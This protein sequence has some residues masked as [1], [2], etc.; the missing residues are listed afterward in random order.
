MQSFFKRLLL[1]LF[2]VGCGFGISAFFRQQAQEAKALETPEVSNNMVISQAFGAGGATGTPNAPYRYDFVELFNRGN[3]PISLN[4]WSLQ[5][6]SATG[7][8]W[9]T[10]N[11]TNTTVAPGQYYLIQF[12]SDGT[13]GADLPTPDLIAP[14][15]SGGFLL[16]L[17]RTTGKLALVNST[18]Q[19]PASTCPS[20]ATIVDFLGYGD[21]AS[22]F[23]GTRTANLSLTTAA[24]RNGNGCVDTDSNVNDFTLGAPNPR[25]SATP[26]NSCGISGNSLSAFGSSAPSTVAQG[27]TSL[28]TVT[29]TPATTPASTGITVNCNLSAIA[30]ANPQ[31]FFDNGSN[32]D[33]T[34]NDNIFSYL[35]T[36]P[37][38]TTN[39]T[40]VFTCA[41]ADAQA[42]TAN[43]N[44]SLNVQ[45]TQ[46]P[47]EHILMGNPSNATAV[48]TNE[49]NYLLTKPQYSLSYSRSKGTANWVSWRL[50][51]TW[52]G[53]AP[54]QDDFRPDPA[55]PAG[56]YQVTGVDYSGSGFDRGHLRPSGDTTR[57][58]P[59]NSATFLMTNMMP[60]LAANNQGPWEDFESYL[61]TLANSGNEIYI[62]SGPDGNV[63]T[64]AAGRVTVPRVTWKVALVLPNGSNDVSRVNKYTRTI[65]IVV[66]NQVGQVNINDPWRRYRTSVDAVE[67][68]T[69]YNF[70]SNVGVQTQYLIERRIDNQ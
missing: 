36:V 57:S 19:L 41:V 38:G 20:D 53:T 49:S 67:A 12:A 2:V 32:G 66:P 6:A 60:Q 69:G 35:A 42:R 8:N 17:S 24:I 23:E 50:D 16:N 5:Y 18:T 48:I 63:G 31:T 13:V 68:L 26:T 25:N 21:T 46:T 14:L 3:S 28:L 61:R 40:K 52:I 39:G 44:I 4:G 64:I 9:I 1:V 15:T 30:G 27:A 65:A 45:P 56:W 22:C 58:I 47:E 59:D 43:T 29:V 37:T 55:L 51:S 54:R 34:A 7:S 10:T 33:V 62:I 11:L 70:F